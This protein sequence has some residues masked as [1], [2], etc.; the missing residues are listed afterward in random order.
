MKSHWNF[1]TNH[2]HVLICLATGRGATLREIAEQ[3]GITERATSRIV[4]EL[5]REGALKKTRRGRCNQYEIQ[6]DFPLRHTLEKHR[7]V[8]QLLRLITEVDKAAPVE[9]GRLS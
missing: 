1:L 8:G 2:A 7:S 9:G 3:V 5:V 4:D 6:L